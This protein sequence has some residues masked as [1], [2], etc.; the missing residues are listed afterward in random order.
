L[1]KELEGGNICYFDG[2]EK[3]VYSTMKVTMGATYLKVKMEEPLHN[4]EKEGPK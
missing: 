3:D 2:M 1:E 4:H